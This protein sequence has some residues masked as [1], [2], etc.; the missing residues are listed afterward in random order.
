M[1]LV[2]TDVKSFP[3]LWQNNSM[4]SNSERLKVTVVILIT[5]T[6]KIPS[7]YHI[8]KAHACFVHISQANFVFPLFFSFHEK[9][10]G[11]MT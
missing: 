8:L 10:D 2:M 5:F 11:W 6:C 7:D 1:S 4:G 3:G 9:M